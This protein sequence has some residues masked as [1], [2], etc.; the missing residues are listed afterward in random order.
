MYK[1]I[2]LISKMAIIRG[3]SVRFSNKIRYLSVCLQSLFKDYRQ[4][5]SYYVS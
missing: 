2:F 3:I 4:F 5:L 1:L